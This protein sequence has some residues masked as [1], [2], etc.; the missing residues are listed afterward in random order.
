MVLSYRD[1]EDKTH[2]DVQTITFPLQS[3]EFYQCSSV[4]KAIVLSRYVNL[5]KHWIR[6]TSTSTTTPTITSESGILIPSLVPP[7]EKNQTKTVSP[8]YR[9]LFGKFSTYITKQSD[10]LKD[11]KLIE[12]LEVKISSL[13]SFMSFHDLKSNFE[14]IKSTVLSGQGIP[15]KQVLD[16]VCKDLGCT[17]SDEQIAQLETLVQSEFFSASDKFFQGF[18][19]E[20]LSRIPEGFTDEELCLYLQAHAGQVYFSYLSPHLERMRIRVENHAIYV[21]LFNLMKKTFP[22][23]FGL[24]QTNPSVEDVE[25]IVGRLNPEKKSFLKNVQENPTWTLDKA[26]SKLRIRF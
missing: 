17:P 21:I 18:I 15:Y 26:I 12:D 9:N 7:K 14:A 23:L 1:Y 20:K 22:A 3:N 10:D 4:R 19:S 11:D 5:M 8:H 16:L 2:N 6:D 24:V 13:S 25:K